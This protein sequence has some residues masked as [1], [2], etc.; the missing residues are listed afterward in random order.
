MWFTCVIL[1]V[2]WSSRG[3]G[4]AGAS[5]RRLAKIAERA[6]AKSHLLSGLALPARHERA[7][8]IRGGLASSF[9]KRRRSEGGKH[10]DLVQ[11]PSPST[12]LR[13]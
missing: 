5:H 11:I 8:G 13:S 2:H 4:D 12:Q 7:R 3:L 10:P 9:A 1:C 6:Q